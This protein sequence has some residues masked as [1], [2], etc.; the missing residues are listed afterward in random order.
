M[1]KLSIIVD[2]MCVYDWGVSDIQSDSI[3][4]SQD[5]YFQCE[6]V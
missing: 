5:R 2:I 3:S 4:A 1:Q 6:I